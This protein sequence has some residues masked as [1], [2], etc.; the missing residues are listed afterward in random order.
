MC[1]QEYD[2]CGRHFQYPP[3][4]SSRCNTRYARSLPG[5]VTPFSTLQ[6]GRVA[7]TGSQ[8]RQHLHRL[9]LSVPSR[10]VESLQQRAGITSIAFPRLFQYP[11]GGSSR[12]NG[13]SILCTQNRVIFQYPPGGSSRYTSSTCSLCPSRSTFSTLQ[14]GRV[15]ATQDHLSVSQCKATFST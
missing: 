1:H 4:G 10:R 12:C 3:G 11:P 6:A 9:P 7:A 8:E 2:E 5:R 13:G 15:A 14:A